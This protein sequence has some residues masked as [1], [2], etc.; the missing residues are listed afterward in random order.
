M[1]LTSVKFNVLAFVI[2]S[3][4]VVSIVT[5]STV[6][7]D[8]V[9]ATN[10]KIQIKSK[11]IKAIVG[12]D[13][14]E[15]DIKQQLERTWK[16]GYDQFFQKKY[17]QSIETERG[18]IKED[19]DFYK[20]YAV[21]GI[22]L[23][24]SGSFKSGMEQIDKSLKLKPNYGYALFNKA[25]ANELY[26]HYDESIKWYMKN[27]E[28]EKFEW[29]YY[30]IASIYGRKGDIKNTIKYLKLAIAINPNIKGIA[31]NEEDFN[32]VRNSTEFKELIP[33]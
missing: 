9:I 13:L 3:C 32:N 22:A 26:G 10:N 25:L 15:T 31:K 2:F 7:K 14:K 17:K 6:K 4:V 19:P 28:I 33:F 27:L 29:S 8:D 1:K 5:Y 21:E 30:G 12:G 24:Y 18:V 16:I 11:K 23:A 20:A